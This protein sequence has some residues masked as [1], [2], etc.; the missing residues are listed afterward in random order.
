MA[1]GRD[2][3]LVKRCGVGQKRRRAAA[4]QKRRIDRR[5]LPGGLR[6]AFPLRAAVGPVTGCGKES[7]GGVEGGGGGECGGP[8]GGDAV[9]ADGRKEEQRHEQPGGEGDDAGEGVVREEERDGGEVE[10]GEA[11]ESEDE[12]QRGVAELREGSACDHVADFGESGVGAEASALA[13]EAHPDVC[14]SYVAHERGTFD[15]ASEGA[16]VNDFAANGGEAAD[17]IERVAAKEDTAAGGS[18][19]TRSWAG[20]FFGRIEHDEEKEEW[21]DE[22]FFRESF[23]AEQNHERS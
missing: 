14:F 12:K 1:G 18:G 19:D 9:E 2:V 4:L 6:A 7:G 20:D 15:G 21:R 23:R 10:G 8:V 5:Q 22:E 13:G 17:A 16:I 11:D 3:V